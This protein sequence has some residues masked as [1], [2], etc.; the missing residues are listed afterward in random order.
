MVPEVGLP[1]VL[2]VVH[3]AVQWLCR[4]RRDS[5]VGVVLHLVPLVEASVRNR[6]L[7]KVVSVVMP[8][9]KLMPM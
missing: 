1:V 2:A 5:R 4:R 7:V 9:W 8:L 3:P 6:M